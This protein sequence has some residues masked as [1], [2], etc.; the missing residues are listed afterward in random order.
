MGD[1]KKR[2]QEY[3]DEAIEKIEYAMG[4]VEEND[5]FN[6]DQNLEILEKYKKLSE[7]MNVLE[8]I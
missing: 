6:N 4:L 2:M 5:N 7:G 8:N 3:I 1:L